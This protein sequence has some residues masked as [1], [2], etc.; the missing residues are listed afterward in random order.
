M[1][2]ASCKT[3]NGIPYTLFA[4]LSLVE[5]EPDVTAGNGEDPRCALDRA[6]RPWCAQVFWQESHGKKY[7]DPKPDGALL[8]TAVLLCFYTR[9]TWCSLHV[10]D[11]ARVVSSVHW[12]RCC[13]PRTAMANAAALDQVM[14][15]TRRDW[16]VCLDHAA[17]LRAGRVT[18]PHVLS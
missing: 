12:Q 17:A 15:T 1:L 4:H 10:T 18:I 2:Q 13:K 9:S 6:R 8:A 14:D 5:G 11:E 7:V 3:I 16:T